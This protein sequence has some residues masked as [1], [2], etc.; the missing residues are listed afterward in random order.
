[1]LYFMLPLAL[2]AAGTITAGWGFH[3]WLQSTPAETQWV[4]YSAEDAALMVADDSIVTNSVFARNVPAMFDPH[5]S[6]DERHYIL[7]FAI[8]AV[9]SAAGK[10][11]ISPD[12]VGNYNLN[13]TGYRSGWSRTHPQYGTSW[14]HSDMKDMAY[15]HVFPL[16]KNLIE[17]L[18]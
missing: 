8:P 12:K 13:G 18:R 5:M 10:R 7:A 2:N 11:T 9:S 17:T 4:T 1:M 14:L 15:R 6:L 16:Y 3:C